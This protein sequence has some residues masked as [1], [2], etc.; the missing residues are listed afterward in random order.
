MKRFLFSGALSACLLVAASP[1]ASFAAP[2]SPPATPA[3][4]Y[5]PHRVIVKL[6]L[7]LPATDAALVRGDV[8][9]RVTARLGG[10]GAEVWDIGSV[11]VA[12]AV[13]RLSSDPRVEFAEPDYIVHVHDVFPNDPLFGQQW[14]LYNSGQPAGRADS[15]IDA[16]EAWAATPGATVLVA[17]VDTGVDL[18]HEDLESAI[19]VNPG[20]IPGNGIDDDGNGMVDDVHGWDFVND[21]N[22]P[23]DDYGHGTHVSGLIAAP[24]NN[25]V[26]MAGVCWSARILPLKF[27]NQVGSGSVSDAVLAIQYAVRM[28]AKVINCSWGGIVSSSALRAAIADAGAHDILCIASTGTTVSIPIIIRFFPPATTSTTSSRWPAPIVTTRWQRLPTTAQ[29]PRTWQLPDTTS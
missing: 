9:A 12:D 15:D 1:D 10:I 24:G 22:D 19:Y 23:D 20:E 14:S 27:L 2:A 13:K 8:S 17:V 29:P 5:A 7:S 16:P 3:P 18:D 25:G 4:A 26:G 6:K 11:P 28:R 21:D